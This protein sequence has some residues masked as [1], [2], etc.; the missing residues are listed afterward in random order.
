MIFIKISEYSGPESFLYHAIINYTWHKNRQWINEIIL[1]N[2]L[3]ALGVDKQPK[4]V[5]KKNIN[6]SILTINIIRT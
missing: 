5:V 3:N 2:T 6:T 1:G 4:A